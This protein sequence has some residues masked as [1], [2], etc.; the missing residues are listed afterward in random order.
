MNLTPALIFDLICL[1]ILL[2]VT[3][4]Y[5]KRGL[6]AGLMQF[7]GNLISLLGALFLSRQVAPV[8][9]DKYLKNSFV[10]RIDSTIAQN[11]VVDLASMVDKYAGFLPEAIKE[12]LVQSASSFLDFAAPDVAER[13]VREVMEPLI[14][15]VIAILLFFVAFALCRLLV[16]FVV[17]VLTNMNH[18][19]LL[20]GVNQLLGMAMGALA[21]C[22]DL[23]IV[24]CAVWALMT[25]T[26]NGLWLLNEQTL[27]GST[28]YR[29]FS[30]INP[31]I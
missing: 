24:L 13:I 10:D 22:V 1:A 25:I 2:G 16:S 7:A 26:D 14:T 15:P 29:L 8:L 20:G 18:I 9:F 3:I 12:K 30:G 21:G 5:A 17:A 11:G 23:Y 6:M 19:P 4:T 28:A 31:F 27:A